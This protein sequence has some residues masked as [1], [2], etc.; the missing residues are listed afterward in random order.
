VGLLKRTARR[1][2][3]KPQPAVAIARHPFD[4]RYGVDTSGLIERQQ[5]RTGHTHDPH[6]TAYFGVPP[7][8]FTSVIEAWSA[9]P[10]TASIQTTRFIDI[11]CGKGRAVLL[12]ASMPFR[13]AVGIELHPGLAETAQANLDRWRQLGRVA[14]DTTIQCGDAPATLLPLL[15]GPV[16]LYLYNPFRAPVLHALLGTIVAQGQRLTAPVDILYLYPEHDDVFEHFPQFQRLWQKQI[17]L[18]PEDANDGL[19]S[20]VDPC[21]LYRLQP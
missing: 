18:S 4:E 5:L 2:L 11:G 21:T 6:T 12:A 17:P 15:S 13:D 14:T 19:S 10:G 1:I 9:T 3:R 8:R 16:L 20:P 7:S